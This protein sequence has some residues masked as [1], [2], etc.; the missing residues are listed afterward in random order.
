MLSFT[1]FAP[2]PPIIIPEIGEDNLQYCQN[3]VRAMEDLSSSIDKEDID[4]IVFIS[5]HTTLSPHNM[6]VS[7]KEHASGDFGDFGHP[8]INYRSKIDLELVEEIINQAKKDKVKAKPLSHEIDFALDHGVLVAYH[9]LQKGL[10]SSPSVVVIGLSSLSRGEHFSFGQTLSEAINKTDKRIAVVASGDLSHRILEHGSGAIGQR[11]DKIITESVKQ[12]D[13]EAILNIEPS[14]QEEA[15]ECGFR[16]LLILLGIL[17]GRSIESKVL[18]YEAPFG[19]GYLV[20]KFD[21]K[22]N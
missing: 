6:I 3:T 4:T 19:V 13:A 21:E 17:D 9:F 5:P 11:F 1:A 2:H 10:T 18:S 15:G 7:Y 16:S 22:Q 20:A 12:M 14:L 8:E